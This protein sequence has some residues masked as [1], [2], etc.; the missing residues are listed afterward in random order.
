MRRKVKVVCG[1][2]EKNERKKFQCLT[3]IVNTFEL[4][5]GRRHERYMHYNFNLM[6]L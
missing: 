5:I 6:N 1:H 3:Y 4:F 2:A